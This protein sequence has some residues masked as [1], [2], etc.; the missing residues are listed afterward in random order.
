MKDPVLHLSR[1]VQDAHERDPAFETMRNSSSHVIP[2]TW[3]NVA[4]QLVELGAVEPDPAAVCEFLGITA[5]DL[6]NSSLTITRGEHVDAIKDRLV[7][8]WTREYEG[9]HLGEGERDI[10]YFEEAAKAWEIDEELGATQGDEL[11]AEYTRLAR[12]VDAIWEKA[13]GGEL[14]AD[15]EAEREAL[16]L[17]KNIL[18]RHSEACYSGLVVRLDTFLQTI[19]A[20]D[21]NDALS[22][23]DLLLLLNADVLR[24]CHLVDYVGRAPAN[25]VYLGRTEVEAF[26]NGLSYAVANR[27]IQYAERKWK[28]IRSIFRAPYYK[29]HPLFAGGEK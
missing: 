8:R 14:T 3:G 24:G 12:Q 26:V 10:A 16:N 22:Q 13:E 19:L 18:W 20:H 2:N 21:D 1:R 17:R 5:V 15:Q 9:S 28:A 27:S 7:D 23:A 11:S 6:A 25:E 29:E 4:S